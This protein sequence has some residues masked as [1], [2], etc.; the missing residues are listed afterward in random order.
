[1]AAAEAL[2]AQGPL[3]PPPDVASWYPTSTGGGWAQGRQMSYAKFL[4][5]QLGIVLCVFSVLLT[6]TGLASVR[7]MV[8]GLVAG[9]AV[10][11]AASRMR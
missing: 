2:F 3:S 5:I 4:A 9:L 11:L 10:L 1:M 6:S 8:I 7:F